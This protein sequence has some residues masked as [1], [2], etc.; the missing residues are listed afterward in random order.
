[1]NT[2]EIISETV[3]LIIIQMA[4]SGRITP[5]RLN[6]FSKINI[7]NE[8]YIRSRTLPEAKDACQRYYDIRNIHACKTQLYL[9]FTFHAYHCFLQLIVIR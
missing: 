8:V 1:M 7:S 5:K 2:K 4:Y 3:Q 6:Y 9:Q